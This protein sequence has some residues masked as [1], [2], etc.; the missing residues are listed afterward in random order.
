MRALV[1]ARGAAERLDDLLSQTPAVSDRPRHPGVP[2]ARTGDPAGRAVGT[3]VRLTLTGVTAE[4]APG[5]GRLAP[6]SLDL[7]AGSRTA[8]VGANG[9]GKSTL[10]AVLARHLDPTTGRYEVDGSDVRD[11]P[12][13]A[14]RSLVAV[15]DD[16][17][18]VFAST[19]RD[20]L[21]LAAPDAG[22]DRIER[23]LADAGLADWRD[24]LVEGLDTRLGAGGLGV[25]GGERARLGLARALLSARPVLLLDEPVAHLDH[26]T[27]VAVLADVERATRGAT[28]VMVS[29]RPEGIDGFDRLIDLE[30]AEDGQ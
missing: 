17:P 22:D 3:G 23:A 7:P 13:E 16:E 12:L 6:T 21:R 26:A 28:V 27:A 25:S 2:D 24:G 30:G 19:L 5:R 10:L 4:W 20:N 15:V 18:D 9:T 11:L 29:H 14:V 1:R 8:F